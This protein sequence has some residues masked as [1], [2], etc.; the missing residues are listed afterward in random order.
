MI[1]AM[2]ANNNSYMG[3]RAVAAAG[4]MKSDDE[5]SIKSRICKIL[6]AHCIFL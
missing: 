6:Y 5:M 3:S 4:A 1:V 2:T